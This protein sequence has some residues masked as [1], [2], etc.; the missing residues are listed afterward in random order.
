MID[1]VGQEPAF[2]QAFNITQEKME[3]YANNLLDTLKGVGAP[4]EDIAEVE[5]EL[6]GGECPFCHKPWKEKL[7]SGDVAT[8]GKVFDKEKRERVLKKET[9]EGY[10]GRFRY[11]TP[12]CYCIKK[13]Q[14]ERKGGQDEKSYLETKLIEAHIPRGEWLS[15]WETWDFNV[16][17]EITATMRGCADWIKLGIWRQG[18]GVILCGAVGTGK[19]RCAIMMVRDILEKEPECAI[20]FLPMSELLSAIIRD[21]SEG[22][23]IEGLLK[24]KVIIMDDMDKIAS[25]K[26]WARSQV[27]SFIDACIREGISLI[28]TTNLSGPDELADKFDYTIVSRLVGKCLFIPFLGKREDDY[29]ILRRKY[30]SRRA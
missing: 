8:V 13:L 26:E 7:V 4:E 27:F 1:P 23:F 22:G 6:H 17:E 16:K 28:G 24:N 5:L 9:L 10:F 3:M 21:Q 18:N 14:Q 11:F 20:R 30:E 25:E 2:R 15:T 29:R 19:T 12:T